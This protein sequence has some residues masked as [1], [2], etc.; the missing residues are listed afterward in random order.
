MK[1]AP[2]VL[3]DEATAFADPENEHLI[4][5]ALRELSHGKTTLMIAHRLTSVRHADRILVV[6]QGKIAESGTH[7]ELMNKGGLYH[8]MWQE[9]Q[10]SIAWKIAGNHAS[11]EDAQYA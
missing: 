4:Q 6:H 10:K 9:Y 1:D 7:D 2:I 3:L 5:K 8:S 11:E